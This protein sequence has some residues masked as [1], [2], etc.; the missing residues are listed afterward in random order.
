MVYDVLHLK[1]LSRVIH[2]I[3]GNKI[4]KTSNVIVEKNLLECMVNTVQTFS[5]I[6][7]LRKTVPIHLTKYVIW[8]ME[9]V[10]NAIYLMPLSRAVHEIFDQKAPFQVFLHRPINA[11]HTLLICFNDSAQT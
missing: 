4:K 2:E 7:E 11:F 5:D 3:M 10:F 1:S 8:E 9:R 6:S